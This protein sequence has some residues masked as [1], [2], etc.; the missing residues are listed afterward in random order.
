[1]LPSANTG[2]TRNPSPTQWGWTAGNTVLIDFINALLL[3]EQNIL[4]V[5]Y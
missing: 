3:A 4:T 1:M 2:L 5:V